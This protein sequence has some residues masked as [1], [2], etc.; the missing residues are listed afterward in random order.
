MEKI[1]E[2]NN[3][4]DKFVFIGDY[5]DSYNKF[6]GPEQL[7]NFNEIVDFKLSQ[8]DKVVLLFGNHDYHYLKTTSENYSGY[9]AA[10]KIDFAETIHA[11]LDKNALQMCFKHDTFLFSHAG[12]TKTWCGM[13]DVDLNNVEQSINDLFYYNPN[14]FRFTVGENFD[15]YGDDVCQPPI[16]V[17]PR[18]LMRDKIDG[19]TQIVGHTTVR[20]IVDAG[21]GVVMID[22]LGT[23]KEFIS[24]DD[25]QINILKY[26]D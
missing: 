3:T 13:H 17:R 7:K 26:Q 19:Y 22:A 10:Y 25:G 6:T 1:L 15:M 2:Q 14:R 12:V 5:F 20:A 23:S 18:S 16:W 9:Q 4:F 24:I 21:I 8:P 11:A